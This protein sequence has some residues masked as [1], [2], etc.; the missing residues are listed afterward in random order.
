MESVTLP[1]RLKDMANRDNLGTISDLLNVHGRQTVANLQMSVSKANRVPHSEDIGDKPADGLRLDV[2]FKPSDDLETYHRQ[3]GF[4]KP[5]IFS[6]VL[7][8]RGEKP[9]DDEMTDAPD[10]EGDDDLRRRPRREPISRR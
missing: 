3:N 5:H 1:S 2:D 10:D 8:I 7:A 4:S 9:E 6:Q